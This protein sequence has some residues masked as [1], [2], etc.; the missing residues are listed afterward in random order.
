MQKPG[1]ASGT[2]GYDYNGNLTHDPYKGLN[3]AYN[4]LNLPSGITTVGIGG[5]VTFSYDASGRKYRKVVVGPGAQTQDYVDGIEYRDGEL[6][7]IYHEEGRVARDGEDNLR[8]EFTIRDHLDNSRVVFSDLNGNGKIE[9]DDPETTEDNESKILQ[10][11]HY[12]PFGMNM[13]G[14]WAVQ[15][16]EKNRYQYNG[17]ELNSDLGLEW[18]DYGAR[19]YDAAIGRFTGVDPLS[20]ESFGWSSYCY[21]LNNPLLLIDPTGM[22]WVNPYKKESDEYNTV[23]SILKNLK[24]NDEELYNYIENLTFEN[25]EGKETKVMVNVYLSN[26]EQSEEK[27]GI[28]SGNA[29]TPLG[30]SEQ[31][32]EF[33]GVKIKVPGGDIPKNREDGIIG[34]DKSASVPGIFD[35]LLYRKGQ[36]SSSLANEAGN[37]MFSFE[38][39]DVQKEELSEKRGYYDKASEQYSNKVMATF[40]NRRDGKLSKERKVYPLIYSKGKI[41]PNDGGSFKDE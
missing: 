31:D 29:I 17:K 3:I 41:T 19:W 24:D 36:N 12:Y 10:E 28:S 37:I 23:N 27:D 14:A 11:N 20:E 39:N 32:G 6:E 8:Y 21:V 7:A 22:K 9:Q 33:N 15:I 25:F 18:N 5:T 34:G 13:D 38:Y 30:I 35:V 4:Y 40:N 16:G 2:Y 1:G 26:L